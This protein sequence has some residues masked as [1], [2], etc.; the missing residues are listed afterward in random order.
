M[1]KGFA[2]DEYNLY[3]TNDNGVTWS[4]TEKEAEPGIECY[5]RIIYGS[6][7][8]KGLRY[9]DDGG[10]TLI[11]SDHPT[12]NF[13]NITYKEK[14]VFA[15]SLDGEGVFYSQAS[16]TNGI[17][18]IWVKVLDVPENAE[19]YYEEGNYVVKTPDV[20]YKIDAKQETP[21][22]NVEP[23]IEKITA[24]NS[25][26]QAIPGVLLIIINQVILPQLVT[27][28]TG[29]EDLDVL[30]YFN[31]GFTYSNT[32]YNDI[33]SPGQLYENQESEDVEFT[34]SDFRNLAGMMPLQIDNILSAVDEVDL[35]N[36]PLTEGVNIDYNE[37]LGKTLDLIDQILEIKGEYAASKMAD[38]I[39]SVQVDYDGF[40]D[41]E[42]TDEEYGNAVDMQKLYLEVQK[43][44]VISITS[45]MLKTIYYMDT[46]RKIAL[47]KAAIYEAVNKIAGSLQYKLTQLQ[48]KLK[49]PEFTV[50]D[51][52]LK[53]LDVDFPSALEVAIIKYYDTVLSNLRKIMV[54]DKNTLKSEAV[55]WYKNYYRDSVLS[56]LTDYMKGISI[57]EI[58]TDDYTESN[59]KEIV[60][61][62]LEA[63][64]N[65]F[66]S[67]IDDYMDKSINIEDYYGTS[68]DFIDLSE[69]EINMLKGYYKDLANKFKER[70]KELVK[71]IYDNMLSNVA[72]EEGEEAEDE[73]VYFYDYVSERLAAG[74]S[75]KDIQKGLI[76]NV[77]N[78]IKRSWITMKERI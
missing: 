43:G 67:K 26:A 21:V 25:V 73:Y 9:S 77:T 59:I 19:V 1:Y 12:G 41:L 5:D 57:D 33:F 47:L 31:D 30:S 15:Y 27:K 45:T 60:K 34:E 11:A 63:I 8:N 6:Q 23:N 49:D 38:Q 65:S 20:I 37:T 58:T 4:L 24:N 46:Q 14:K 10:N 42:L 18:E 76:R 66:I 22:Y 51:D 28:L 54:S 17:G 2:S 44:S 62:T 7:E 68:D 50:T 61:Q 52:D 72:P 64:Y 16:E 70:A 78:L 39:N 32:S 71:I 3:E 13:G 36:V 29:S 35:T 56:K 75:S 69:T 53:D 40:L 74:Q 55:V 48:N